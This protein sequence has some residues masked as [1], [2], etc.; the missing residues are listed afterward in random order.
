MWQNDA[1][2]MYPKNT[3]K[4]QRSLRERVQARGAKEHV[5]IPHSDK[6]LARLEEQQRDQRKME[7]W[8]DIRRR[9]EAKIAEIKAKEEDEISRTLLTSLNPNPTP[10]Q[11]AAEMARMHLE[12]QPMY[13]E[14]EMEARL[15][16]LKYSGRKRPPRRVGIYRL[17]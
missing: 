3:K 12:P 9:R 4:M 7:Y 2:K 17:L 16:R 14:A 11:L 13:D 10:D 8:D 1:K 6:A 5:Y 15:A